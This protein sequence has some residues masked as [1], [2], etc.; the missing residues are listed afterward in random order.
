MIAKK[1]G[2]FPL[3]LFK[4]FDDYFDKMI[5]ESK[6]LKCLI[7]DE[8]TT[9]I[10]SLVSSQ[11]QILKKGV[12]LIEK[13]EKASKEKLRHLNAF[14]FVRPTEA[15]INSIIRELKEARFK[16]Y[17][18]FFSNSLNSVQLEKLAEADDSNLIKKIYELFADFYALNQDL[19]VLNV[20]NTTGFT[21][22]SQD[23]GELDVSLFERMSQG[24]LSVL[25]ATK[26]MPQIR[27]LNSS[28]TCQKLATKL[29]ARLRE[30]E[31]ESPMSFSKDSRT[32]LLIL[33]RRED[34]ITPLLNQWTYQAML[35]ELIGIH[36]NRIDLKKDKSFA[37]KHDETE[38]VISSHQDKFFADNMY[39]NFGDLADSIKKFID[40]Y[41]NTKKQSEKK[42]E[43]L[44]DM[45]KIIDSIPELTRQSG[46]LNKHT[47]LSCEISKLIKER[48]VMSISEVEQD[49][50]CKDSRSQHLQNVMEILNGNFER[51][52]KL[53]LVVLY[54]L[55]YEEDLQGIQKLKE[56][57][58]TDPLLVDKIGLID[59][60]LKYSSKS[61]RSGDLFGNKDFFG[62]VNKKIKGAMKDVPNVFTQHRPYLMNLIDKINNKNLKE[63]EYPSTGLNSFKEK[64][65]EIIIFIVGGATFEEAREIAELNSKGSTIILGGTHMVNSKTML[66]ELS[67]SNKAAE[68][69]IDMSQGK[70]KASGFGKFE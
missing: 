26:R 68:L 55:K 58:R 23:W 39:K 1:T 12:Y 51:F 63:T 54:A 31:K 15:N 13:I 17:Y 66:A 56:K 29:T 69:R 28:E 53:K 32:L 38:F 43:S 65:Y 5:D 46:N 42:I 3:S 36:N 2:D 44:D 22:P 25:F 59:A 67:S 35:H 45:Q 21:R 30:E 64:P 47:T 48:N 14:F 11:S 49:I 20:F 57:L 37:S 18:L 50:A 10:I 60:A 16:D 19:F 7:L 6:D 34:P 8:E 33:D 9:G 52:D 62:V 40:D 61:Q 70:S 41:T 4:Y 27:Y 24:L